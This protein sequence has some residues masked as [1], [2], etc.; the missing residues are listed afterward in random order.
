M[1]R[2]PSSSSAAPI[3]PA[4]SPVQGTTS[5]PAR[6][7]GGDA[8]AGRCRAGDQQHRRLGRGR[9]E[10]RVERQPGR[11]VED[12]PLRLPADRHPAGGEQGV[13]GD[14]GAD[15]DRD[16]IG[17]GPP[18]MD[19]LAGRLAG[20]PS[21]VARRGRG[22][23]V[24]RQRRLEDDQRPAGAGVLA[25][26][27]VEEA[28]RGRGGAVGPVDLDAAVAE[29]AGAAAAGLRARIVGGDHDPG[30][31]GGED[32]LRAGRLPALVGAR[33]EGHEQRRPGRVGATL[34]GVRDRRHL[35]MRP[36]ELG[37]E[38]LA[39]DP[40]VAV[41]D[42]RPDQRVRADAAP[43]TLRQPQRPLD[44]RLLLGGDVPVDAIVAF[45]YARWAV[46]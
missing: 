18:A 33:L 42:H 5:T 23:A 15:P 31:A 11:R 2:R 25:E 4:P 21:R 44:R 12:D 27:L 41:D 17:L 19:E 28:G 7:Q 34:A 26:R 16:G 43:A 3:R 1:P 40:P 8:V 30:D 10:L 22:P 9:D 39:D 35:G 20:D 24:E 29:D 36:A 6:G 37:V 38:A 45:P 46:D 32:R 14:R 13:V